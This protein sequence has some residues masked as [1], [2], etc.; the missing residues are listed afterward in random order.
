[1]KKNNFF[2][3]VQNSILLSSLLILCGCGQVDLLSNIPEK[4]ANEILSI[5]QQ[6]KIPVQKKSGL[7]QT[8]TIVLKDSDNFSKAVKILD[9][10]GYPRSQYTT[11]GDVFQKSGL[12]SSPLEERAR[13]MYALSE[14]IA[15]TLNNIPGVLSSR[16]HLVL[17]ENDP[18]SDNDI[19][20]SAAIFLTYKAGENLDESVREIKYLVANSIQGLSYDR[21]SIALFPV[22]FD[23]AQIMADS[24]DTVSV[25]GF[26]VSSSFAPKLLLL[27]IVIGLV[28]VVAIAAAVYLFVFAKKGRKPESEKGEG[29]PVVV[30]QDENK[31]E[32]LDEEPTDEKSESEDVEE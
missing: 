1:M 29:E 12:V 24:E 14:S 25:F 6:Y 5:M 31:E 21:V 26:R 10:K 9:A 15:E 4:E 13:F 3:K 22:I 23:E 18:Y 20:S 32:S 2:Q 30:Q 11:M 16:V 28:V 17:P 8:W 7:E 19:E 27:L